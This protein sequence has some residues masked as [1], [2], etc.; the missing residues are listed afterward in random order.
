M[1]KMKSDSRKAALETALRPKVRKVADLEHMIHEFEGMASDLDRQIK[2]EE[3]RTRIKD[4][5]HFAYSNFAKS[6]RQR[7]DNL[8]ASAAGLRVN[9]SRRP[10]ASAT[11]HCSNSTAPTRRHRRNQGSRGR[12]R[13]QQELSPAGV[14]RG[15]VVPK[16]APLSLPLGSRKSAG[17]AVRSP[18]DGHELSLKAGSEH[19]HDHFVSL[20]VVDFWQPFAD[21][22]VR[23]HDEFFSLNRF[24]APPALNN[25]HCGTVKGTHRAKLYRG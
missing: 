18:R 22:I 8:R 7:R 24:G 2:A 23:H 20:V 6:A 1:A 9:L 5:V 15:A 21:A 14:I 4:P 16:A 12:D 13:P 10:S 3:H 25:F 11:M 19:C 17:A